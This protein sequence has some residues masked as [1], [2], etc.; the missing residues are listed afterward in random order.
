MYRLQPYIML[1]VLVGMV[2]FAVWLSLQRTFACQEVLH[3]SFWHCF[4]LTYSTR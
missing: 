1:L 2:V 4:A 3:L